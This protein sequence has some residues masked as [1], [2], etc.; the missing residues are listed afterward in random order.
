MTINF[1][2]LLTTEQKRSLLE[3][4]IAQFAAEGYQHQLN[5]AVCQANGDV[6]GIELAEASIEIISSAIETHQQELEGLGE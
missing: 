1:G 6:A 5:L 4:R 2:D 3:Q